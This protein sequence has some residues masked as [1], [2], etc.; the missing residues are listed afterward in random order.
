MKWECVIFI[1]LDEVEHLQK[2]SCIAT[3]STRRFHN[4]KSLCSRR[5]TQIAMS[6]SIANQTKTV[7]YMIPLQ[8]AAGACCKGRGKYDSGIVT[9]LWSGQASMQY[10]RTMHD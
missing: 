1:A 2:K 6:K 3:V 8:L 10:H 7:T 9:I 5:Y 4:M